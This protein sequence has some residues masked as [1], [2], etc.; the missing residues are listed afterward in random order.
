LN[1]DPNVVLAI[2]RYSLLINDLTDTVRVSID[3]DAATRSKALV[4]G[5]TALFAFAFFARG[6]VVITGYV[7]SYREFDACCAESF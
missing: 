6:E 3:I 7:Y 4:T 2:N 1:F 5:A